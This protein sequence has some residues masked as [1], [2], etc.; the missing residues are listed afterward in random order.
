MKQPKYLTTADKKVIVVNT[1]LSQNN[2]GVKAV[3][4]KK[5]TK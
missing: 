2:Q 4:V 1:T 5:R 3:V